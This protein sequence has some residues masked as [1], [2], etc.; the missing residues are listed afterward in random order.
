[1]DTAVLAAPPES[2][3]GEQDESRR[4]SGMPPIRP[5]RFCDLNLCFR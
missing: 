3:R 5:Y 4:Q 1:M 2:G